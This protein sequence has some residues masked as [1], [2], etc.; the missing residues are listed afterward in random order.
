V[1]NDA[2]VLTEWLPGDEFCGSCRVSL[3]PGDE[4]QEGQEITGP[5]AYEIAWR[6]ILPRGERGSLSTSRFSLPPL[7]PPTDGLV[8]LLDT[9]PI[10][11]LHTPLTI[12][13]TIRN[14][15]PSR[16]ANVTVHL[17]PEGTDG[18]VVAGLRSGRVP[19]LL[20]GSEEHV[21]WRLVP[22]EC[23]YVRVPRI[24][25]VD[26]RRSV[27]QAQLQGAQG[28]LESELDAVRVVDVRWDVKDASA[29]GEGLRVGSDHS[30]M[31][32]DPIILVIP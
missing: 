27:E 4:H 15:H 22:I 2:D 10:A 24:R 29:S 19:I 17:E 7:R 11:K 12:R 20:P 9:P 31:K 30:A 6:R 28:T 21:L 32:G 14:G 5:G 25:V 3:A 13:L 1:E 8:A 23:G 16:S 26:R 18:F